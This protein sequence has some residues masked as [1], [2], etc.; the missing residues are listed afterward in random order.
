MFTGFETQ[1]ESKWKYY[2]LV[3]SDPLKEG[4]LRE[5]VLPAGVG[6]QQDRPSQTER[7]MP[8]LFPVNWHEG[9]DYM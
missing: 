6:A 3:T 9:K 1:L 2:L 8:E 4:Q 7:Q 5:T